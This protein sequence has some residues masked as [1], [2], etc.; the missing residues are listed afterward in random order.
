VLRHPSREPL[1]RYLV[2][3]AL[4]TLGLYILWSDWA[5]GH[6]YGYR[7]LIELVPTLTL[8]LAACW[9][10]FI[11]SRAYLRA[12]FLVAMLASVYVH[13]LGAIAAPCGFDDEP[14]NIDFDHPRLWDVAN[15]EIVRCTLRE[16]TAWAPALGMHEPE[17][18]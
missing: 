11:V 12:L 13:G 7:Y 16:A 8:L 10:R 1:L 17:T 6:T 18:N 3:S 5:A 14:N 4:P 9:E 15:G 2:W